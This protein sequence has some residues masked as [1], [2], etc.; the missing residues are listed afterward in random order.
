MTFIHV[1]R[2]CP[3]VVVIARMSRLDHRLATTFFDSRESRR[4]GRMA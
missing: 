3:M 2:V 1:L 4:S